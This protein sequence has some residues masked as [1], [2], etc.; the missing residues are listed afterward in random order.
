MKR[1]HFAATFLILASGILALSCGFSKSNTSQV[2]DSESDG[3]Q[4]ITTTQSENMKFPMTP[5]Q[6]GLK[7]L[8]LQ[9]MDRSTCLSPASLNIALSLAKE[10]GK[11]ST[12]KELEHFLSNPLNDK[13]VSLAKSGG[14]GESVIIANAL[15]TDNKV[16]PSAEY[17][18]LI[19]R[20]YAAQ[21]SS[22]PFSSDPGAAA[23]SINDWVKEHTKGL[24]ERLVAENDVVRAEVVITNAL[25]FKG[26]WKNPFDVDATAEGGFNASS[27]EKKMQMM[28]QQSHLAY[29]ENDRFMAVV[30]PYV[31]S[32]YGMLVLLP[33]ER[34]TLSKLARDLEE[35][36]L[37]SLMDEM[38]HES[39]KLTFP[40]FDTK[41]LVQLT[42]SLRALGLEAPFSSNADFSGI[43]P[44]G[45]NLPIEKILQAVRFKVDE[46][47]TEAAAAT[48]I[49]MQ[50]AALVEPIEFTADHP[51]L[52][53][54][55][56]ES[57]DNALFIG[58]FDPQ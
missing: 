50:R 56:R 26:I 40:K 30:L 55:F 54:V 41:E 21:S 22:L 36:E 48:G 9:Q 44:Q 12:R 38:R 33:K 15:W 29:A 20:E 58:I 11:G 2:G 8:Q 42:P 47:K 18:S 51:F 27:G 45:T 1:K 28:F 53:M 52:Y 5:T 35:A 7:L 24:I 25:Y 32:N 19:E 37:T 39:V 13:L 17:V 34:N 23:N 6:L 57:V 31:D 4:S 49:V 14:E 43:F 16:Q 10:G 3:T 46:T